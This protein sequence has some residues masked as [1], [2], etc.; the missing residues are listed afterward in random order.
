MSPM[1]SANQDT[2]ERSKLMA[3]SCHGS[4]VFTREGLLDDSVS[5]MEM[6]CLR[7]KVEFLLSEAEKRVLTLGTP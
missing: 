5:R 2:G 6:L 4:T 3:R 1:I 7:L